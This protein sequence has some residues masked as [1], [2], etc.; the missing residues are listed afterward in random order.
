M[1][2]LKFKPLPTDLQEVISALRDHISHAEK[3]LAD[4]EK[5]HYNGTREKA[6]IYCL[7][8]AIDLAKGCL[9][10]VNEGLPDSLTTLSR[11]LLESLFWVRYVTLSKE[12]A[13]HFVDS[14]INEMKRSARK[15]LKAGYAKIHH[16]ETGEDKTQEMLDSPL[17][18]GIPKRISI[19]T[20]A[21]QGGL[22]R[23][24]TNVYGFI[25]MI[26]HGKAYD[27]S[28]GPA[29][30]DE[31]YA[32]LSSALG[33]LQCI[34]IITSDWIRNRKHTPRETLTELLGA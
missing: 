26:A 32:P 17:L 19:E 16:M 14:T 27:L 25:S 9:V 21:Q 11:A 31:L 18:K 28:S 5:R 13:Q 15:N 30:K 6:A 29:H 2:T 23:V 22:E 8:H 20:A 12:N 33:A 7:R 10:T 1:S 34:E 24:Y 4:F 3:D